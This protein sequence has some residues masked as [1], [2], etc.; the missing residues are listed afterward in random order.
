MLIGLMMG[1]STHVVVVDCKQRAYYLTLAEA[2]SVDCICNP[3]NNCEDSAHT[4][5]SLNVLYIMPII[6]CSQI[7]RICQRET[8]KINKNNLK[9]WRHTYNIS[10][11]G[12]SK[13]CRRRGRD[14]RHGPQNKQANWA[15]LPD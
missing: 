11:H 5:S 12:K 15:R 7:T 14:E 2:C 4:S 10:R 13:H 3:E 1:T 6:T 8:L 9:I